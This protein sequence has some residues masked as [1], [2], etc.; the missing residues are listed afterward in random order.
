MSKRFGRNQKRK[1]AKQ[2]AHSQET[3]NTYKHWY[4]QCSALLEK[5]QQVV[6]DTARIMGSHFLTLDPKTVEVKTLDGMA[7]GWR[8]YVAQRRAQ[9]AE[10]IHPNL[11]QPRDLL[12]KMLY[13]LEFSAAPNTMRDEQH[14]RF[15]YK[16]KQ[17]GYAISNRA[18]ALEPKHRIIERLSKE[19]AIMLADELLKG[20]LLN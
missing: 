16:G 20:Q 8:V 18:L 19:M 1:M 17:V 4:F 14:F 11:P 13:I 3:T 5:N 6:E 12:E 9:Y 10:A 2:L 7:L 15:R